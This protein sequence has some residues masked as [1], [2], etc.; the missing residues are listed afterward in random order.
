M[1]PQTQIASLYFLSFFIGGIFHA[2][3]QLQFEERTALRAEAW[4]RGLCEGER[5][6]KS[7]LR[8]ALERSRPR[9]DLDR[10]W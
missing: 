8:R 1:A 9:P 2:F 4:R 5:Q 6:R 3:R 10:R 7:H